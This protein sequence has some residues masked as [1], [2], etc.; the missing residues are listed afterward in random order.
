VIYLAGAYFLTEGNEQVGLNIIIFPCAIDFLRTSKFTPYNL[1]EPEILSP[2]NH[3]EFK[4][5]P[6]LPL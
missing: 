6:S 5:T 1:A 2:V 4:C 3:N